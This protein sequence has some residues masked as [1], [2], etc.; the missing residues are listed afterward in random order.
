VAALPRYH[1]QWMPD[2]IGAEGGAFSPQVAQALRAMGH[3]V[4]LPGDEA[5]GGRGSSHVWGN[6]QTVEWRLDDNSLHGGS[7][8]RNPVGKAAVEAVGAEAR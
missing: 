2:V 7:D 3:T 5:E 6:L 4:D 8:P 1:H